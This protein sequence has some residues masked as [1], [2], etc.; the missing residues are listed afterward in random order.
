MTHGIQNINYVHV[1]WT[2]NWLC[3][4]SY[5]IL[6]LIWHLMI[7]VCHRMWIMYWAAHDVVMSC[8]EH[9]Q[10]VEVVHG[11]WNHSQ[12]C[13]SDKKLPTCNTL[14][15]NT[16]CFYCFWWYGLLTCKSIMNVYLILSMRSRH[17]TLGNT[18]LLEQIQQWGKMPICQLSSP[19]SVFDARPPFGGGK[20]IY[21]S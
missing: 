18:P 8:W 14:M 7:N 13:Y 16:T 12:H 9:N 17:T 10:H 5:I 3:L 15:V 19:S 6:I 2:G 21:Y 4:R 11:M 1:Q 20:D